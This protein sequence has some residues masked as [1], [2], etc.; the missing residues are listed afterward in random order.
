MKGYIIELRGVEFH[1]KG[2][3]LML[4]AILDKVRKE[5]PEAVFVMEMRLGVPLSKQR[6]IGIH[7]KLNMKK[8]GIDTSYWGKFIPQNLRSKLGFV[9]EKDI[10]VVLDSSG[11]A[12]GDFWGAS[13]AGKRLADHI[14]R[15]KIQGKKVIMLSQAFGDFQDETLKGKM[16]I[17]LN[18]ADLI[19]ARDRY[20]YEYLQKIPANK[21]QIHVRPDFTN[22]LQGVVPT[23]YKP[24]IHEIGIIPNHK[25]LESNV[26]TSKEKYMEFLNS[27]IFLIL[28]KKKKP[29]FLIHEGLKDL[30]IAEQVNKVYNLSVPVL[31]V[32]NPLHVKGII[33][34]SAAIITSRFHG[35][36]SALSQ[37]V[38]CLCIGWSHKY[39]AL[40]EDYHYAEGLIKDDSLYGT[41][42]ELKID[43]ILDNTSTL[44]TKDTLKTFS[45]QQKELAENMWKM[46][47]K[48]IKH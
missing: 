24:S 35:L 11:F 3:E 20:S 44:K 38:P 46:V 36:V 4:Y 19:F 42:L 10:N 13:K 45:I 41:A 40:M 33:G 29:Y 9:L 26:F 1:N 34:N 7:T 39:L 27:V 28:K 21:K 12:F 16:S 43:L 8:F 22:L 15:W 23:Y 48:L 47:F 6:S 5:L 18:H 2:A 37:A 31:K 30:Q 17:I 32:E 25:L 14:E